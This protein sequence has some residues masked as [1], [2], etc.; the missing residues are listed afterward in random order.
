MLVLTVKINE[1]AAGL[2]EGSAGHQAVV[3]EGSTAPLSGNLPPDDRLP[4]V[5]GFEDGFDD[6]L[7]FAGSD[8]VGRCPPTDQQTHGSDENALACAG[9]P[10][11]DG[12]ARFE[13]QLEPI[14][15]SQML[16]AEE[17]KH[18]TRSAILS[19]V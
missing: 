4:A 16:D 14:D 8:Q 13:L 12:Q 19:D 10:R 9:L 2:A 11:E 6:G 1:A 15:N 5:G 3:D 7:V 18:G 17:S